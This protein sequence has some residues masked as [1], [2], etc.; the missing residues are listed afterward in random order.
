MTLRRSQPLPGLH[1]AGFALR[2]LGGDLGRKDQ[3]ACG[4]VNKSETGFWKEREGVVTEKPTHF[5]DAAPEAQ[6]GNGGANLKCG[7]CD[8]ALSPAP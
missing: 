6:R 5:A 7:F 1:G 3:E 4:G 8:S 2:T